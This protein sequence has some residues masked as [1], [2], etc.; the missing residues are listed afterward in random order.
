MY[1]ILIK[2]RLQLAFSLTHQ[3]YLPSHMTKPSIRFKLH[4]GQHANHSPGQELG[5]VRLPM[6][7]LVRDL[8][9]GKTVA[10]NKNTSCVVI[11]IYHS[12]LS[13]NALARK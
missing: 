6:T 4:A 11:S 10:V 5:T 3:E 7:F 13:S 9:K 12:T 8:C 2:D 1:A